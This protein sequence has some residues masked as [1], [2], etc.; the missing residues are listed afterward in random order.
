MTVAA[1]DGRAAASFAAAA[2]SSASFRRR[3]SSRSRAVSGMR[4]LPAGSFPEVLTVVAMQPGTA[5]TRIATAAARRIGVL[6][7]ARSMQIFYH[8]TRDID[9]PRAGRRSQ[10][11]PD[12]GGCAACGTALPADR[13]PPP[14]GGTRG[15]RGARELAICAECRAR[16]AA[17]AHPIHFCDACGVSL[18]FGA[19]Q[20]GETLAKDGRM[21]CPACV[22]AEPSPSRRLLLALVLACAAA[23]L[24]I[25]L[26]NLL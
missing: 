25:A 13:A 9:L 1:A 19:V 18:P 12:G 14:P 24:G 4:T 26:A 10:P 22:R 2:A 3:R 17:S 21:L 5:A 11:A 23:V 20:G 7:F 8:A 6:V 16:L 15:A